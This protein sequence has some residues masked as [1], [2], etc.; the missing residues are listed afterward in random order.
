MLVIEDLMLLLLD[1]ERGFIAGEGTLHYVLGGAVLGEL[2]LLGQV[3]VTD[4]PSAWRSARVRVLDGV[5][6]EDPLLLAGLEVL[7]PKERTVLDAITRLGRDQRGVVTQRLAERGLVRAE[8]YRILGIFPA[9]RWPAEQPGP[10]DALRE[11]IVRVMTGGSQPSPRTALLIGLLWGSGQLP[12]VLDVPGMRKREMLARAKEV[13][14]GDL[15]AQAVNRAVEQ[16]N[17]AMVAA[18]M[19]AVSAAVATSAAASAAD[20]GS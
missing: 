2:A 4:P 10:E 11:E 3:D 14:E 6:P 19:A 8:K 17:A 16:T 15:S 5:P 20:G 18:T 13:A 9:T 7:R 12:A 1:D